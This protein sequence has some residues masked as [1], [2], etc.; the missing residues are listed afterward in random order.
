MT[1]SCYTTHSHY[2]LSCGVTLSVSMQ[3]KYTCSC[4]VLLCVLSYLSV[5]VQLIFL[6]ST[7]ISNNIQWCLAV[8]VYWIWVCRI[9][10]NQ[11]SWAWNMD[12]HDHLHTEHREQSTCQLPLEHESLNF[13]CR[14]QHLFLIWRRFRYLSTF[15]WVSCHISFV[16]AP[17]F[18]YW[19]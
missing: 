6:L 15:K 14:C 8:L 4:T 16:C 7:L 1:I 5:N 13:S 2:W 10:L 17:N 18:Q 19:I 12:S 11:V 3:S 9:H